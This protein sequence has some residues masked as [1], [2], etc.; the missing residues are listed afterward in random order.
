MDAGRCPGALVQIKH[1]MDGVFDFIALPL[2]HIVLAF[3]LALEPG[4]TQLFEA[5]GLGTS[6][7]VAFGLFAQGLDAALEAL[8]LV[9]APLVQQ[10]ELRGFF[11]KSG[12]TPSQRVSLGFEQSGFPMLWETLIRRAYLPSAQHLGV[13]LTAVFNHLANPQS[14][15]ALPLKRSTKL[16]MF[17]AL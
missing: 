11:L 10:P 3:S 14:Y 12:Y 7:F 8:E 16:C 17:R 6:A 15:A 5:L 9:V 13:A 4:Q 2:C 1:R